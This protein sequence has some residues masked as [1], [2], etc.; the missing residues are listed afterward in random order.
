M[1]GVTLDVCSIRLFHALAAGGEIDMPLQNMFWGA[2]FGS[3]TDRFG[4]RWMVN[5]AQP[6]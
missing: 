2:Y 1:G 6:T 4:I 3:L 5:C